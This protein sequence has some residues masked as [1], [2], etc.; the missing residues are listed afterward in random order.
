MP[1]KPNL[2]KTVKKVENLSNT[3]D[4]IMRNRLIVAIFLIVDGITFMLNPDTTL[5]EMARNI[6]LLVLLAAISVFIT[7]LAS[8]TKDA[9][10]IAI[11]LV[12]IIVSII[13]YIYPD[14]ISAYMQLF[15]ALFIIYDGLNNLANYFNLARLSK[16]TQ[17]LSRKY[18]KLIN[19]KPKNVN[20]ERQEKLKEIDN[21]INMGLEEQ[22]EKLISPLKNIV[23]KSSKF[24]AL[25]IIANAASIILGLI[26]LIFPGVSMMVWGL[27]FLYTGLSNL[28]VAIKTMDLTNKLKQKRF[29]EIIFDAKKDDQKKTT[30][31]NKTN[32]KSI[33][34]TNKTQ[35]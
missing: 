16:Y 26:L 5:P 35:K 10:T 20:K 12:I 19:R 1:K 7:N 2:D 6:I 23:N 27:I 30:K 31:S 24:S 17:A 13:F 8:K 4:V 15:L 28:F 22:K 29:K 33:K 18:N 21:N 34:T 9:K 25:Y 11:S 32:N 14:I 3:V